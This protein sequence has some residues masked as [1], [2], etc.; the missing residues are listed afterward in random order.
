MTESV[1]IVQSEIKT[2]FAGDASGHD[3]W[4]TLRVYRL[5]R[6]LAEAYPC[7]E[8]LVALAALLHDADD[9]KLFSGNDYRNTRRILKKAAISEEMTANIMS[10]ISQVSFHGTDSIAPDSLEGKIVQDA[11]RLDALG[12]IGIART[13]AYGG[14]RGRAMFDPTEAP[15]LGLSSEAYHNHKGSSLHH[16]FEK[17][18]TLKDLMNTEAAKVIA[19]QRE[20]FLW[21]FVIEF[22]DEW[23]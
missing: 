18:F 9:P 17:L 20:R 22:Y 21:D 12:A 5:A 10:I 23:F 7:D 14:S 13:F 2:L 1:A 6:R 11:D 19:E 8:T 4:H 16:F 3:Y 15:A